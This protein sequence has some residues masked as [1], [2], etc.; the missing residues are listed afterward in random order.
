MAPLGPWGPSRRIAVAVSGGADSMAL[1]WLSRAW[2]RPEALIVDHRLR[3]A[4]TTEATAVAARLRSLNIPTRVLTLASPLPPARTRKGAPAYRET[5]L[6]ARARAARYAALMSACREAGLPHLLLAHHAG[7]QAETVLMRREHGSGRA[8]LAGMAAITHTSDVRLVRPLLAVAPDRLRATLRAA[9]IAWVE[10]PTNRDPHFLRPRLRAR[11][12][13]E[14]SEHLLALGRDA[15]SDRADTENHVAAEL[16][17]FATIRPEGFAVVPPGPLSPDVLA[18]V[19]QMVGGGGY[20]PPPAAVRRLAASIGPATL[21]GVRVMPAGRLGPGWLLTREPA[22]MQPAVGAKP[23]VVW[24][25]RFRIPPNA[26]CGS[27]LT[28]GP[29]GGDAARLRKHSPLPAAVLVTLPAWRDGNSLL[30]VPHLGYPDAATCR[31]QPVGFSPSR[32][33]AGGPFV[34]A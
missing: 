17:D 2:G 20:P 8:G 29:L 34:A 4:S 13:A 24:D 30:S 27:G 1:A 5:A 15:A 11:L 31:L 6:P 23:G 12:A 32:P 10:D 25:R 3:T 21:S 18:A 28:L 14:G 19:L 22:A 16:A 33:A 26:A 9:G 7:D